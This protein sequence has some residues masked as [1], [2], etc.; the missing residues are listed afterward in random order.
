MIRKTSNN[1]IAF[2][3]SMTHFSRYYKAIFKQKIEDD[4]ARFK[5]FL[6][7]LSRDMLHYVNPTLE[8]SEFDV[9]IIHLGV[10]IS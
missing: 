6:D 1:I 4:R 9:T 3:D 2:G 5:Y 7:A 8:E 10:A